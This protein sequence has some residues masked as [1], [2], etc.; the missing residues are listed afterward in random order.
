MRL[1]QV[2]VAR[3]F[4]LNQVRHGS[5]PQAVDAKLQPESD[6]AQHCL[7]NLG[8][9]EIQI[10]LVRVE[11]MPVIGASNWIPGPIGAFGVNEDDARAGIFLIVV[12]T[13]HRSCAMV[14]L[15]LPA[16]RAETR[17]AGRRCG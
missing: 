15:A 9:I 12:A 1:R 6:H 7:E 14:I 11:A 2:F 13:R 8:I 17:G 5:Q 16:W 3:A 4:A 10:G